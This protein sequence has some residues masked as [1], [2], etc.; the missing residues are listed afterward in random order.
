MI[1]SFF[2]F[3]LILFFGLGCTKK[4]APKNQVMLNPSSQPNYVDISK[5]IPD[6]I[7]DV[8]YATTNNFTGKAVYD[9]A[10]VYLVEEAALALKKVADKLRSKEYR[11]LLF[12]GYRPLEV[13]KTF[14]E[15]LPDPNYVADPAKGS[16]HNRGAAIDLS[17]ADKN[18]NPIDMPTDYDHFG[19]EAHHDFMEL[20]DEQIKNRAT[21]KQAMESHGFQSLATEWWHYDLVG[22]EKYPIVGL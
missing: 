10:T 20:H 22:W 14:W 4:D 6:A 8:R 5:L 12:D 18:G 2:I 1:K 21:L 13:Q 7:L 9:S 3:C 16:R 11:L 19:M 17:L 15:I